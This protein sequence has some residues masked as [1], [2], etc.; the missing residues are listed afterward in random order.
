MD[1]KVLKARQ[2][3][4][5][6]AH[7]E[8]LSLRVHRSLSWLDAAEQADS[9]WDA[10]FVFLW[11][12][13]NAAYAEEIRNTARVAEQTLFRDFIQRLLAIDQRAQLAT[14][15]WQEYAKSIRT[16][17][18]NPYIFPDYWAYQ[19]GELSEES[20]QRRFEKSRRVIIRALEKQNTA[21]VLNIALSRIYTLRNQILHGGSTW[22]GSVNRQQVR[23]C[24][25]IMGRLVPVII[26]ILMDSPETPWPKVAYPVMKDAAKP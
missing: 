10:R 9:N 21:I 20:W 5:R 4:E 13:F 8:N 2:R 11:V 19:S 1:H 3:R 12:A 25:S 18:D 7:P 17:I 14:L 6:G 22:N 23:D 26:E 15:V 24:A 16:L